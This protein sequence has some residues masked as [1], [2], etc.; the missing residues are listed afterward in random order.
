M[1]VPVKTEETS[2]LH[3]SVVIALAV[4]I[5]GASMYGFGDKFVQFIKVARGEQDGMF[6]LTPIINY[7][8]ASF[9]FLCLLGWAAANGMFHD[10]ELPKRTMLENDEQLEAGAQ[11]GRR[12]S[13][14]DATR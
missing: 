9:G 3:R 2:A 5:L 7:L 10:I 1:N 14:E 4:V 6:A 11:Y 8:M 12:L 13:Q